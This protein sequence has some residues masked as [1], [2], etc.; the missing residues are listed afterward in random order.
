MRTSSRSGAAALRGLLVLATLLG[1]PP[2]AGAQSG[3]P[4]FQFP[5]PPGWIRAEEGQVVAF[6]PPG[7]PPQSVVLWVMPPMPRQPD[8]A[9]Q[10]AA[11]RAA[12]ASGAGLSGMRNVEERRTGAGEKEQRSHSAAYSSAGGDVYLSLRSRAEG[13][14]VGMVVFMAT[15]AEAYARLQPQAAKVF[16][17]MRLPGEGAAAGAA[18]GAAGPGSPRPAGFRGPGISGVWMGSVILWGLAGGQNQ[19]VLRWKTF[20]DDGVMFA[21]LPNAGLL[22]FDRAAAQAEP[23]RK[24]YWHT[25]SFSGT[26]GETRRPGTPH[27]WVLRLEKPNQLKVDSDTFYRCASVDGLR[28]EGAWTSYANPDDPELDRRPRG[29][30]PIIHF[31]RDG[32]FVDEG[33]FA[34]FLTSGGDDRAGSG[35]YELRDFTLVLRYD[36]GRVRR[37]AF[38]GFMGADP[39]RQDGQLFIRRSAMYKRARR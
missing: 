29:Q 16:D 2:P 8:F 26:T 38:N 10:F 4:A 24:D 9:A 5:A 22:G 7:E 23:G 30:R 18:A 12:I 36:D 33:L 35:R 21:D 17:G 34:V 14:T 37:E 13:S 39:A 28:L 25:Y 15:S 3:V 32:R 31:D 27:P 20:F 6:R 11:L 1:A 19:I